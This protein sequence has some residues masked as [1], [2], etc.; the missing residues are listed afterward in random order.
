MQ[1]NFLP[2]RMFQI[3]PST[4]GDDA[5]PPVWTTVYIVHHIVTP[6]VRDKPPLYI[7]A[8]SFFSPPIR[9]PENVVRNIVVDA[10]KPYAVP[11]GNVEATVV[12]ASL[13]WLGY[14]P[15]MIKF[16]S[17]RPPQRIVLRF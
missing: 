13:P 15:T 6:F 14:P 8:N 4:N 5:L 17:N 9:I 12:N 7:T 10:L 2:C 1:F 11:S 3:V 16:S